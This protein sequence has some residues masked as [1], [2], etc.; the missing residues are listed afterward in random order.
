M[1]NKNS[2]A[3]YV[4]KV[5]SVLG[6]GLIAGAAGTLAITI[7]QMIEMKINKRKPSSAPAKAASKVLDVKPATK[8]D[9][10]QLSNQVHWAYGTAWGI[11]RGLS[12]LAGLKRWPATALHFGAIYTTALIM[13]PAL[14]ATPP[15]R[16]WG[17][18]AIS[19]DAFH[20][21]VYALVA[22]LVYDE[23]DDTKY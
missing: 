23:I 14:K 21:A 1:K 3:V 19:I 5:G 22:G 2:V 8:E 9:A 20:H 18:K 12:S 6:R 15:V 11:V 7:S 13:P 17:A 16:E 10:E 4:G